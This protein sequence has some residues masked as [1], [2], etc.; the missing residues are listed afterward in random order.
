MTTAAAFRKTAM[1]ICSYPE[2]RQAKDEGI[3]Q[4]SNLTKWLLSIW[5]SGRPSR[6]PD[7]IP[8][9]N[10][11][12]QNKSEKASTPPVIIARPQSQSEDGLARLAV[13]TYRAMAGREPTEQELKD[14]EQDVQEAD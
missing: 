6:F 8:R 9:S 12:S 13:E 3:L 5:R 4:E 10:P 1:S 14:L 11:M 2:S 7:G